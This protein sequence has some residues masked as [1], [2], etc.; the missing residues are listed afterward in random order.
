MCRKDVNK[1]ADKYS[2]VLDQVINR[3]TTVLADEFADA[4]Q[5]AKR[6]GMFETKIHQIETVIQQRV[7]KLKYLI[8][9]HANELLDTL[10]N[11]NDAGI[12]KFEEA[13]MAMERC[14]QLTEGFQQYAVEVI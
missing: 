6:R 4:D 7:T 10:G 8:E 1:V 9:L 12:K 3:A 11:V 13:Q 2:V 5:L 14:R